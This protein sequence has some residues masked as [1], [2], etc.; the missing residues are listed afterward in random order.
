MPTVTSFEQTSDSR[1]NVF[2][3]TL[4]NGIYDD[5]EGYTV[6]LVPSYFDYI[7]LKK[8]VKGRN[9]QI[10]MIS[11]YTTTKDCH[12]QRQLYESKEKPVL[13]VT[14]RA[15]VFQKTEIRFARNLVLYSLPESPD[16]I[17]SSIAEAMAKTDNHGWNLIVKHRLNKIKL[18]SGKADRRQITVEEKIE[19]SKK[20]L[21]EGKFNSRSIVGL[22]N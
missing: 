21:A 8:F 11:E 19:I 7:R 3:K 16:I 14:E 15:L 1:F 13:I 18:A 20:I 17:E 6:V 4:W 10:A 22:F 2:T 5:C 9:A 12:R